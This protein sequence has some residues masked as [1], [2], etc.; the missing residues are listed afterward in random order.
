MPRKIIGSQ[1]AEQPSGCWEWL[2]AKDIYNKP[3]LSIKG[4][5]I[6]V[7]Y[8][9]YE[10]RY[11]T[12]PKKVGTSCGNPYCVNPEHLIDAFMSKKEAE[13]LKNLAEIESEIQKLSI[14][15][16]NLEDAP[17]SDKESFMKKLKEQEERKKQIANAT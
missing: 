16:D 10:R 13:R 14:I 12:Y 1:I 3:L 17:A 2:G 5:V 9:Y 4:K 7:Q 11:N 6:R 8:L 15:L